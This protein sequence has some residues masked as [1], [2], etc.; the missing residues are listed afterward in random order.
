MSYEMRT[1]QGFTIMG[2]SARVN[3]AEPQIIGELWDRFHKAGG[4]RSVAGRLDDVVYSAYTEYDGDYTRPYTVLLG[5]MV[6]SRA[7]VT[8]GMV[9]VDVLP[10]SFAVF[11]AVGELPMSVF[12]AWSEVWTT[13]LNRKYRTDFDRYGMDGVVTVHVGVV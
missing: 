5:C 2:I 6:E 11:E 8:D 3:P 4:S 9:K 7:A 10:G 1:Q 12:N 13:S